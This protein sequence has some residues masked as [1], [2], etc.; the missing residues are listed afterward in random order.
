MDDPLVA[1]RHLETEL[2]D[3]LVTDLEMPAVSGLD[4]LVEARSCNPCTQVVVVTGHSTID[5]LLEA[6][7]LGASDYLLKPLDRNDLIRVVDESLRRCVRWRAALGGTF[8]SRGRGQG[9]SGPLND[10]CDFGTVPATAT[11]A[12]LDEPPIYSG[13]AGDPCLGPIVAQF[14]EG[15]PDKISA[16]R[17]HV[18]GRNYEQVLRDAHQL[19]GSAGSYGFPDITARAAALESTA[20]SGDREPRVQRALDELAEVCR[21]ARPGP[22]QN[23]ITRRS[24]YGV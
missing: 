3:L 1:L 15:L 8:A 22:E 11:G 6:L 13:L 19:K 2:V 21:R 16:L 12:D 4:L 10:A 24:Q 5:A 18:A 7:E 20:R 17:R 14:V 23:T 9:P